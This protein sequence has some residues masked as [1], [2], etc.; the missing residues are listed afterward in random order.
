MSYDKIKQLCRKSLEE[1]YD[2]LSI[3]R[4]KNR[5]EGKKCKFHQSKNTYN[6]CIRET[7][8]L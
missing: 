3:D 8:A 5:D 2:Y 7:R 6:H 1:E 4:S